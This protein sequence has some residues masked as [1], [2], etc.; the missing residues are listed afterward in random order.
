M[1]RF[2]IGDVVKHFKREGL[3]NPGNMYLYGIVAFAEHT[4]TNEKLVVYKALY[5]DQ[6][7]GISYGQTFARPYEM[8][9]SEVDHKKY[10][11]AK[12]KYR[13]EKYDKYPTPTCF[14]PEEDNPYPLCVGDKSR[15]CKHCY[16]WCGDP[17]PFDYE[18]VKR[19]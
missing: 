9:M 1:N 19:N 14:M 13:F 15:D 4:E 3:Q 18:L 6:A 12:Q 5:D 16:L 11:N 17:E 10:P 7:H 2:N 8:F